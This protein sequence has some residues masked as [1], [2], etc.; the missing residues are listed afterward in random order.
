MRRRPR[1][2]SCNS[3]G[4]RSSGAFARFERRKLEFKPS[5][6]HP[7]GEA[8]S[9]P[10]HHLTPDRT[11]SPSVLPLPLSISVPLH[12]CRPREQEARR[13]GKMS[14]QED[15]DYYI[16]YP[17][18]PPSP[19]D[20]T[21][22]ATEQDQREEFVFVYEEDK[23]PVVILLGWAGCQ[24]RYLAK[25]SSIYEEKRYSEPMISHWYRE[26]ESICASIVFTDGRK[27]SCWKC[28]SSEV[29]QVLAGVLRKWR[30]IREN[31]NFAEKRWC[32]GETKS[33]GD[34]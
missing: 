15:L 5:R 12:S 10:A 21:S 24:D 2:S 33:L 8:S 7:P 31:R 16:M 32:L 26:I 18:F 25:Y 19:K 11:S 3:L 13:S 22:T 20:P 28:H 1:P 4:Y 30:G 14:D 34:L 27:S 9:C 17:S 6:S 23:R 29:L